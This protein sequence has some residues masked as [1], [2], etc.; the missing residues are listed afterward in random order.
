MSYSFCLSVYYVSLSLYHLST[1]CQ[2]FA[3]CP[4]ALRRAI[5]T[6]K[7]GR[8][9]LTNKDEPPNHPPARGHK[10]GQPVGPH[11]GLLDSALQWLRYL[12]HRLFRAPDVR[13]GPLRSSCSVMGDP[14]RS[15]GSWV[16]QQSPGAAAPAWEVCRGWPVGALPE[17][18]HST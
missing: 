8:F 9:W 7:A 17:R 10:V 4:A 1:S 14:E 2:S 11:R 18:G 12:E 6:T 5:L 13:V 16:C 3:L 15:C